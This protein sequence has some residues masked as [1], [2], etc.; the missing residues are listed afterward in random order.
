MAYSVVIRGGTVVDGTGAPGRRADVAFEGDRIAEIGRVGAR[1][2][3]EIDAEGRLVTPGF[4]DIHTHLDAQVGWD[5]LLSS[6][7]WHGVTTAVLGNCGVTFAPCR[8]RDRRYLAELMESVEDIPARSILDGLPW[9]WE[10]YGDY[11]RTLDRMPKGINLAGMVG[12]CA[13]RYFAMGERSLDEKPA[14]TE[15][16]ERMCALVDEAIAA[17][18]VGFSTSRTFLHRVPDG[19]PVP[20]THADPAELLAIGDV[21]GRRG[22]G[23]FEAAARLG[24][25]DA[26]D[27]HNTRAEVGWM[28]ELS[29]RSGRPAT[30][31]LAHSH[32]RPELYRRVI[33]FAR[34]E[35]RTGARLRPQS[36]ARGIGFLMGLASRTPFDRLEGWQALRRLPLAERL[37]ALADP[38]RR[39]ALVR[40]AESAPAPFDYAQMYVLASVPPR[41]D[42]RPE[43]SL[44]AHAA[45]RGVSAPRAFVE[46]SLE[47][48]GRA[49]FNYPGLN[50][51]MAAVEE[52]LVDP[53]VVMGLADA[54]AHVGQIM[55]ASQPSFVLGYWVRERGR[56]SV[57]RAVQRM[58]QETAELFG[59]RDRGVLSAGAYA[60]L[61]VID[62]DAVGLE[63][64]EYVHDFPH[65][66]GRL[67]QRGRGMEHTF[68]NGELFMTRGE[69]QGALAGRVLR[70]D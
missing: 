14:S 49:F 36:T 69:H 54:G 56:I 25:R 58:T 50:Q 27:L 21:M 59:L 3:L 17:G 6:S 4:V 34:E 57:E 24:E 32:R 51:D 52:M 9:D 37:A 60:D 19:R 8:E 22:R 68:V 65:G 46:I 42:N 66:A 33:E 30:F 20:G 67:V 13:V 38:E 35:N 18:A 62:L 28:G 55:D 1:G 61:N 12:H 41:Y 7:C 23:V 29:R 44:A 43:D 40:A 70:G 11:L 53:V 2:E 26:D 15:D 48:A 64:P 10:S 5:P 63:L 31:G 47:T 16:V 45:R 39:E